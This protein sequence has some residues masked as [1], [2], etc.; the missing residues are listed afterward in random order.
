MTESNVFVMAGCTPVFVKRLEQ[1]DIKGGVEEVYNRICSMMYPEMTAIEQKRTLDQSF[2]QQDL[3]M[4]QAMVCG[5]MGYGDFLSTERLRKILSWQGSDGC[6]GKESDVARQDDNY[7]N[8]ETEQFSEANTD[9]LGAQQ[10]EFVDKYD[11][12]GTEKRSIDSPFGNI[13]KRLEF[14]SSQILR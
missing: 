14:E 10:R 12:D 5:S 6:F 4:E 11:T 1:S 8:D 9:D 13:K 7:D 2:Y 3:Y